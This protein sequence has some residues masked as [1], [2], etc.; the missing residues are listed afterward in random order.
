MKNFSVAFVAGL[1]ILASAAPAFA[2]D[3][4]V[5]RPLMIADMGRDVDA[6]SAHGSTARILRAVP[7]EMPEIESSERIGGSATVRIDLNASGVVT[8]ASILTP[9]GRPR[10]D[11]SALAAV[12][13]S[14]YA[15]AVVDGHGVGGSY[16]VEVIFDPAF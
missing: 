13:A 9:S 7:A 16:V 1:A 2:G 6:I 12:R 14:Q 3:T 4:L 8:G 10:F 5:M 15:P 11:R